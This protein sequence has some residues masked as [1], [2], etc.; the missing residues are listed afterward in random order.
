MRGLRA[1]YVITVLLV[2]GLNGLALLQHLGVVPELNGFIA[3]TLLANLFTAPIIVWAAYV[4]GHIAED[5]YQH[6]KRRHPA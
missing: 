2:I 5:R 6:G 3:A 4:F 1:G